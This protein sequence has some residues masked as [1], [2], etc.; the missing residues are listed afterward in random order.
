MVGIF[1][2]MYVC[3]YMY[4]TCMQA[5]LNY[6]NQLKYYSSFIYMYNVLM[7]FITMNE[8]V[9][10]VHCVT[11]QRRIEENEECT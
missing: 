8:W 4:S 1:M 9:L 5:E 6:N 7:L 11:I 2:Y 3:M 10:H